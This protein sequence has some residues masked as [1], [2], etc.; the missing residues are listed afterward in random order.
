MRSLSKNF[1]KDLHEYVYQGSKKMKIRNRRKLI[2]E[3]CRKT[4]KKTL[5]N[6]FIRGPP[7]YNAYNKTK[8]TDNELDY[9]P[10]LST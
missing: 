3:V 6:T 7:P 4:S 10:L 5:M 8:N 9:F 2:C 1:K